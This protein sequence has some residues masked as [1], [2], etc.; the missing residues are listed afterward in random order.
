MKKKILENISFQGVINI[1]VLV[2]YSITENG[3]CQSS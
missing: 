3:I 2:N 1:M